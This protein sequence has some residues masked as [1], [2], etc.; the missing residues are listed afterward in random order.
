MER[1][2]LPSRSLAPLAVAA[3]LALAGCASLKETLSAEPAA[4]PVPASWT[5][6]AANNAPR[7]AEA[8][9]GSSAWWQHFG[10]PLLTGLVQRSLAEATDVGAATAR[11]R[12][13]RAARDLAA[14]GLRPSIGAGA[15]AQAARSEGAPVSRQYRAA[16]D[17]SWEAD[18]WG[19]G[20]AGVRAAEADV[21]ASAATLGQT[22]V[23]L[24]AE[25]AA[26][27]I[28]LRSAQ[29][30]LASARTQLASQERTLALTQWREQAGL[31]TRLD[32]EQQQTTVAQTR[33]QLPALQAS[34]EQGMNAL[35]VLA[36]AA[37]GA[38]HGR[39]AAAAAVPSAATEI[40]LDIPAE[41]LTRRADVA[42]A[43]ARVQA[44]A[45]RVD[46]IDAERLPSLQ[47]S[48]SIGL[49]ALA[50]STLGSGAGFASVL[51]GLDV[52]LFD[53]GRL[54]ARVRA[55]EAALD[56]A[57]I[58]QRAVVLAAL[59]EVEDA[60]VA[61]KGA[62]EQL[63][64]QQAAASAARNAARLAEQRYA[65]GL[66]DVSNVLLTQRTLLGAED[67]VVTGTAALATQ[68]VRLFK[69]LGGGWSPASA[70]GTP[71]AQA[72][73][74]AQSTHTTPS[75][76]NTPMAAAIGSAREV[77]DTAARPSRATP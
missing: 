30:R 27:Y 41:V 59:Q 14:A 4:A 35:A 40:A 29:L 31:V 36:G 38:L 22:Q 28:D 45:A 6:G 23:T 37:P 9:T 58:D 57:R 16:F 19:G 62:R 13:A 26:S 75:T 73:G 56:E 65:S 18:L 70:A 52:P 11:L 50:L 24:A 33:A 39:L 8:S 20:R 54:R 68:Q 46:Q 67:A 25:V 60:L 32:V 15:S 2:A 55:Q 72:T 21:Q 77:P 63:T 1:F 17:A 74:T 71:T 10:D 43:S 61:L 47:L 64:H 12:Q 42:A 3:A 34:I 76:P 66:T 51:A 44:A 5:A 48:G 69:A 49:S 7:A 53:G